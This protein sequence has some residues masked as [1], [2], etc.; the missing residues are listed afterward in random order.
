MKKQE[1]LELPVYQSQNVVSDSE[2]VVDNVKV[3]SVTKVFDERIGDEGADKYIINL[4]LTTAA[5]VRSVITE[6]KEKVKAGSTEPI[7][8]R[9][10]SFNVLPQFG[11]QDDFSKKYVPMQ[12]ERVQV[13]L[14]EREVRVKDENGEPT[15][16]VENRIV[17]TDILPVRKTIAKRISLTDILQ[18]SEQ[19]KVDAE[20]SAK[21]EETA[22]TKPTKS[23]SKKAT[24]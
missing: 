16:E 6:Y 5:R 2:Q 12:G 1:T 15:D 8:E 7:K 9:N 20:E 19:G 4:D 17:V 21:T 24:A 11:T 22:D 14:E 18:A 23:T 10:L 3:R 13:V